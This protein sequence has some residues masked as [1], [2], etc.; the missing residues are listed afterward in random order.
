VAIWVE[1]N[2]EAKLS[3][4]RAGNALAVYYGGHQAALLAKGMNPLKA[5]NVTI[6]RM[7]SLTLQHQ[8]KKESGRCVVLH[9]IAHAVHDQVLSNDNLNI[10]AAYKQAMERKLLDKEA[11]AATNEREFFAEMTCAYYDQLDYYPR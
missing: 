11:Y 8:P 10:K 6:L 7:K 4:G 2:E 9:E 3:S 5:K 1:W